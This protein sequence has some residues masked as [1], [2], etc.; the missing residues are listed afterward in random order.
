M[1]PSPPKAAIFLLIRARSC[2]PALPSA[3]RPRV[4]GLEVCEGFGMRCDEAQGTG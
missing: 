1:T 4:Y 3:A 2:R